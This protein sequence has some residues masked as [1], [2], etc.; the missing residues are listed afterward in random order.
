MTYF[1]RLCRKI[2]F[3]SVL[4]TRCEQID[5]FIIFPIPL[6]LEHRCLVY[7]YGRY[8][9]FRSTP[10]V[11]SL[12]ILFQPFWDTFGSRFRKNAFGMDDRKNIK[13]W[14]STM[15][16]LVQSWA[17]HE[18]FF[19]RC[20]IYVLDYFRLCGIMLTKGGFYMPLACI[21][22][23]KMSNMCDYIQQNGTEIVSNISSRLGG[24]T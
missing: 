7:N 13:I 10:F 16:V 22:G 24:K 2:G 11:Y 12:G 3:G 17:K 23:H 21:S 9:V 15:C 19:R 8:S 6:D 1:V 20:F 5:I 18:G 4:E 14:L